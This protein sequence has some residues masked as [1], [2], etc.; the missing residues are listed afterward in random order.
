MKIREIYKD[1]V[2]LEKEYATKLAALS[3]KAADRKA[4][5]I[6][7]LVVGDEPSK[8]WNDDTIRKR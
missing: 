4:K 8:A 6:A 1:R 7:S 3:K 2:A 5:R